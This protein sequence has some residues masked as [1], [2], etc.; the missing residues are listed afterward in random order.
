MHRFVV[1]RFE[2]LYKPVDGRVAIVH[3]V[4]P[5]RRLV[6]AGKDR[7]LVAGRRATP[8]EIRDVEFTGIENAALR[9]RRKKERREITPHVELDADLL[10][11]NAYQFDHLIGVGKPD[12]GRVG[13]GKAHAVLY[14]D[15]V[16]AALPSVPI[17]QRIGLRRIVRD[18]RDRRV[19]IRVSRGD[20]IFL[21]LPDT[22]A[23]LIE[24][25]LP[26]GGIA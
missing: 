7:L 1:V 2:R 18:A 21:Q 17:Q 22:V 12:A 9:P 10:P 24:Y 23:Y 19:E 20:D 5:V 11:P 26:V 15:A 16:G 13:K 25:T 6:I 8:A 3:D 14:P 4:L